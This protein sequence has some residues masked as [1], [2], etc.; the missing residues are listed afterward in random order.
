MH[1][2]LVCPSWQS[3]VNK[4]KHWEYQASKGEHMPLPCMTK[5]MSQGL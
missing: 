3:E 2:M 1:I 4:N 5:L